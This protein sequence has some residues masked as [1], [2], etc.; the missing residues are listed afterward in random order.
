[1]L[2]LTKE[3]LQ[4]LYTWKFPRKYSSSHVPGVETNRGRKQCSLNITSFAE[5]CQ[6]RMEH[7]PRYNWRFSRTRSEGRLREIQAPV[8]VLLRKN[9]LPTLWRANVI[10]QTQF[11]PA[12]EM[13]PRSKPPF[14]FNVENS[15]RILSGREWKNEEK[16]AWRGGRFEN[17]RFSDA[18]S[19]E[20]NVYHRFTETSGII[21][22]RAINFTKYP[23]NLTR[24]RAISYSII[25]W[26]KVFHN[27][28][29]ARTRGRKSTLSIARKK[30]K[31][32]N[33]REWKGS[34]DLTLIRQ[35]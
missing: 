31:I 2:L 6:E 8:I 25:L 34:Q 7:F 32:E 24:T 13:K 9:N 12:K 29:I 21:N 19:T 17:L 26:R 30:L 33:N 15:N 5:E 3:N 4:L 18:Y 16:A 11:N 14:P 22:F 20:L 10:T 1:M 27:G 28:R 23:C 35:V